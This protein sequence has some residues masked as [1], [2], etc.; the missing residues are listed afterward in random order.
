MCSPVSAC[1]V[2][3]WICTDVRH[4]KIR[5]KLRP[6]P[7][8]FHI[9]LEWRIL[10]SNTYLSIIIGMYFFWSSWT[11]ILFCDYT[12]AFQ[13]IPIVSTLS[14]LFVHKRVFK[15]SGKILWMCL[16]VNRGFTFEEIGKVKWNGLGKNYVREDRYT[17]QGSSFLSTGTFCDYDH[18]AYTLDSRLMKT[19][20]KT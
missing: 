1:H 2:T 9:H 18:Q 19:F 10:P 17:Y 3:I 6:P 8:G 12:H 15:F 4:W 16:C 11:R 14:H 13:L 20:R 5:R 7:K